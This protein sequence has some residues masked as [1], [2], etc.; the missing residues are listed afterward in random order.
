MDV[1][2]PQNTERYAYADTSAWF[3][4]WRRFSSVE[5]QLRQL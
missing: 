3:G 1:G 2:E 4:S 5:L